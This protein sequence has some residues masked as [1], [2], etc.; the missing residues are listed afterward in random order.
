[1]TRAEEAALKAYPDKVFRYK[2]IGDADGV[3]TGES[4]ESQQHI[5]VHFIEG[6]EQAK[7]D[8]IE[9]VVK[10]LKV[11]AEDYIVNMTGSYPDA[12]FDAIIGG[13]CWDEL[14]KAMKK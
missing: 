1:M 6:Y 9:R 2:K 11:H 13:K 3:M 7:K 4:V 5:R 12:P 10:W 14:E 8:T